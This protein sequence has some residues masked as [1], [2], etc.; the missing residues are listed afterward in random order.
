V[1]EFPQG[2]F[3][4]TERWQARTGFDSGDDG[5][6]VAWDGQ[7]RQFD[8]YVHFKCFIGNSSGKFM[9]GVFFCVVRLSI[10]G[11]VCCRVAD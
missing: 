1:E 6:F 5:L 7:G 4:T 3:N 10:G 2:R 8:R 9:G 11:K